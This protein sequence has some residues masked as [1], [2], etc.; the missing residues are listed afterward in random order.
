[1]KQ[2]DEVR[3][4]L[5]MIFFSKLEACRYVSN[6]I[7]MISTASLRML[8]RRLK[9]QYRSSF[10]DNQGLAVSI[11]P[12]LKLYLNGEQVMDVMGVGSVKLF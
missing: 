10:F 9:F 8:F 3:F 4:D 2:Y 12:Y 1:M 7:M 11:F 5:H 6:G